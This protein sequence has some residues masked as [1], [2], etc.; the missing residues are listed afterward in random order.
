MQPWDRML[1]EMLWRQ[2]GERRG[3]RVLDF[4][5][6]A[7][8]TAEHFAAENSVTA[9]E[10]D[11]AMI[12]AHVPQTPFTQ[13]VGSLDCLQA[14]PDT[15]FDLIL[16]HN[17]LEYA[18]ERAAIV[19]ALCRLLVPGGT[20]SV[21]KHNRAGR[22]MQMAVLLDDLSAAHTLLDGQD[23]QASRFGR[24]RYYA[25]DDLTRWAPALRQTAVFGARTFWDLQQRQEKHADPAWQAQMLALEERVE[26]DETYRQIAFFH[27]LL[28]TRD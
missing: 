15:S 1:H 19:R 17:V 20:L 18:E 5:S 28:L 14:L 12:A 2:L 6:G 9:I 3:L 22:V 25:D 27:H 8:F 26:A 11:P 13:L 24:I 7:G 10:P 23:S 21:C 16:C 4:G